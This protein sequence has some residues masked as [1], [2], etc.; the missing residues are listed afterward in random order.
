MCS[1]DNI[2]TSFF[3]LRRFLKKKIAD[4]QYS[5]I[6]RGSIYRIKHMSIQLSVMEVDKPDMDV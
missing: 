2:Q 3:Y 6:T 1:S 5:S 4:D